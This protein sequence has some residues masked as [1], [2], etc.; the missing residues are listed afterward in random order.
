MTY[1][2][3]SAPEFI[4]RH[5][6]SSLQIIDL[7]TPGENATEALPNTTLIPVNELTIKNLH[8][9]TKS[10]QPVYFLCQSGKR[11][12]IAC[13]KMRGCNRELYIIEGGLNALKNAD[14]EP[15]KGNKN[16]MSVERQVRICAG[17]LVIL[18]CILGVAVAP[19]L[20]SISAFVGAGLVFAGITD[21]C[22]MGLA[23]AKMPWNKA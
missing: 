5:L 16:V 2:K 7:R 4:A 8:T 1:S 21:T 12:D 10:D 19:E 18:G 3:I 15:V 11:A 22:A 23:L 6:S 9:S 14:L 20:F 13:N 17:S